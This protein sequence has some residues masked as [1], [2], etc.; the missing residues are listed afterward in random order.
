[1]NAKAV[2][3]MAAGVVVILLACLVIWS[4]SGYGEVSEKTY[5]FAT[6]A[7]GASMARSPERIAKLE[8][9]LGEQTFRDALSAPEIGWCENILDQANNGDWTRAAESARR[10][11]EDQVNR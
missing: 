7:Y 8:E 1:M 6:A 11:M 3:G 4:F 9:M 2:A 5:Q 10:I